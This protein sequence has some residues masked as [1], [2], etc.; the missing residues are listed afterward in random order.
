MKLGIVI[1]LGV[2]ALL[3]ALVYVLNRP[4]LNTITAAIPPDFPDNEFSHQVFER[5]LQTYVDTAGH[6]DYDAWHDSTESMNELSSYMAAVARY[7]PENSPERFGS[8][9]DALAYWLYA[10]NAAV[11]KSILDRWPLESVTDVRAPIEVVKGFGFFYRQR[12]LFGEKEYSLYTIENDKIR[13]TF[14]DARIHFVLNCGSESC[15]VL[16]PD[17]PTGDDLESFLQL[18]AIDFVS[19]DRNVHIDHEKKQIV[20]SDIFKWFKKDFTNDLR[21][22]GLPSERGLIDYIASIAGESLQMEIE[23][24][25]EYEIVFREYDWSI[26]ETE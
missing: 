9:H 19:E 21:R 7:S 13:N 24:S 1:T 22:R 6:V 5:L 20:L 14:R 17:L 25:A 3:L 18:A 8:Q 11:I 10:Y 2:I 4:Q 26:N 23:R 16:R 12:F 15:P